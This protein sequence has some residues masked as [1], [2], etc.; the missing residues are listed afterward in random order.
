MESIPAPLQGQQSIGGLKSSRCGCWFCPLSPRY[1]PGKLEAVKSVERSQPRDFWVELGKDQA[2]LPK[3]GEICVGLAPG[4]SSVAPWPG[5]SRVLCPRLSLL[6]Q[7]RPRHGSCRERKL[8]SKAQHNVQS[9]L[10][11]F[12]GR[13][14][15]KC[16]TRWFGW[17]CFSPPV[18]TVKCF[19]CRNSA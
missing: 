15:S 7:T 18:S 1:Q 2:L 16:H 3:R 13:F 9:Q 14:V 8:H 11:I 6:R 12:L 19:S 10:K 17:G 4:H 5:W